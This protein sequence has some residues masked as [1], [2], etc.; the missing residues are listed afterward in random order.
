MPCSGGSAI[1]PE[2]SDRGATPLAQAPQT[3]PT[4]PP[5]GGPIPRNWGLVLTGRDAG[6][7]QNDHMEW[8]TEKLA[9]LTVRP[10]L[11]VPSVFPPPGN[12]YRA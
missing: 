6:D 2:E 7:I 8:G 9:L 5:K 10:G 12:P 1:Q 4:S 3:A 11:A